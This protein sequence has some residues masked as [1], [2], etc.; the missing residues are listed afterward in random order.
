MLV[1]REYML[2]R[3]T[4]Y[5]SFRRAIRKY[6]EA[7]CKTKA[8]YGRDD[9]VSVGGRKYETYEDSAQKLRVR[10]YW[11]EQ[12]HGVQTIPSQT[13]CIYYPNKPCP[14]GSRCQYMHANVPKGRTKLQPSG[15][16]YHANNVYQGTRGTT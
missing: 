13:P 11:K 10:G 6:D 5:H 7:S 15:P 1:T 14:E 2:L 9:V 16:A 8:L 3:Q 4:T 12:Y